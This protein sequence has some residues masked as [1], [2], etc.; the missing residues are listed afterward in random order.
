MVEWS[1]RSTTRKLLIM[2]I[3]II[4]EGRS[5]RAVIINVLKGLTNLDSSSFISLRPTDTKDETDKS[6][7][8][9]LTFSSWSVVKKECEDKTRIDEFFQI[10]GNECIVI[11]MDSAECEEYPVAR[12]ARGSDNYCLDLRNNHINEIN[13]WLK[14]PG[15]SNQ[16]LYAIAIE[17]IDAWILTLYENID[18]STHVN[19][20]KRLIF[21]MNRRGIKSTLGYESYLSIS[22]DFKKNKV[23]TNPE[24]QTRNQ[25][26]QEFCNEVIQKII[27]AIPVE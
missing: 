24:I 16:F 17:E 10:E 25:S 27:P 11:H 12:P 18:S 23:V 19:P 21:K 7:V 5:D 2:R 6:V 1:F 20:K 22:A 9:P 4:C 15:P 13:G 3:G 26:L 14:L 8:D